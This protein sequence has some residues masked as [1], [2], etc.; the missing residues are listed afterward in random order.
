MMP[1]LEVRDANG[2]WKTA[3]PNLSFPSGKDKTLIVDLARIFPTADHHVRIRTNLQIYWDEAFV[4][5]SRETPALE[6]RRCRAVGR[7]P[8][9][10]YSRTTAKGAATARGGSTTTA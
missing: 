5:L 1:S 4:A 9:R 7:S 8:R 3:N 6:S 10:G 2:A